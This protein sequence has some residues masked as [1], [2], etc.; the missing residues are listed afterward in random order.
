MKKWTIVG[1]VVLLVTLGIT[2][3]VYAQDEE[4]QFPFSPDGEKPFW[5]RGGRGGF[6]QNSEIHSE[7][8]DSLADR[9]DLT[10]EEL[11]RLRWISHWDRI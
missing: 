7:I 8:L 5:G 6:M 1:I 10:A 3:V 2:G 4:P 9:L 11:A